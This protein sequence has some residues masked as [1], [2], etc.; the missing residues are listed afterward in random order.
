MR[1]PASLPPTLFAPRGDT[2]SSQPASEGGTP[3]CPPAPASP[4]CVAPPSQLRE[5]FSAD[6]AAVSGSFSR[7][8]WDSNS[9]TLCRL[10]PSA[11]EALDQG[12]LSHLGCL[13]AFALAHSLD[14]AALDLELE[15]RC[16]QT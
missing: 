15:T 6:P 12:G 11:A 2:P 3:Q 5:E 4:P 13:A 14:A 10:S 9:A 16:D 7:P 8:F 1:S